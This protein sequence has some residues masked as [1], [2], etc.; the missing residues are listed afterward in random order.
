MH[1]GVRIRQGI[2]TQAP[3]RQTRRVL[4]F[5]HSIWPFM[6]SAHIWVL[7]ARISLSGG[8]GRPPFIGCCV[9][10]RVRLCVPPPQ[11]LLHMLQS[12]QLLTSQFTGIAHGWVLHARVSRR[13]GQAIP[14]FI[15]CC[16]TVRVRVCIPPPQVLLHALNSLQ[17]LTWQFTGIAHGWVLH[18]RVSRRTGQAIPPFIG[19]CVTVRVRVCIPP[20]QVLLHAL[21]SLQSL[22]WQSTGIAH[23]WVLHARVS[24]SG[25]QARPPLVGGWVTVRVRVCIPPPQALLHALHSL[26]PLTWQSLAGTQAPSRQT[27][28]GQLIS[29]VARLQLRLLP[30]QL[31][32]G[33]AQLLALQVPTQL[34]PWHSARL[35]VQ[36]WGVHTGRHMPVRHSPPGQSVPG[37]AS[38]HWSITHTRQGAGQLLA[39]QLL[40]RQTPAP[41]QLGVAAG[42]LSGLSTQ[43]PLALQTRSTLP[44]PSQRALPHDELTGSRWQPPLPSQPF[45]QAPSEQVPVGSAP[46][47]GTLAQRPS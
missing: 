37:A 33:P 28:P 24:L 25:G 38:T 19:C 35:P 1:T 10:V 16:V 31:W 46:R 40:P 2:D 32:H 7:Q 9:T 8:H 14:P 5:T 21:N 34:P 26:Q 23:G 44:P 15:G 39:L 43:A 29:F 11:A 41:V 3:P 22:T 27:P 20:P 36:L 18:A 45:V 30:L 42:Q 12:L 13:T 17:S 4:P 6:H 47:A